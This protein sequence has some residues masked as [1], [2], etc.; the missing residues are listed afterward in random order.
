MSQ[1]AAK[2]AISVEEDAREVLED[3][4]A[5]RQIAAKLVNEIGAEFKSDE[6]REVLNDLAMTKLIEEFDRLV[7]SEDPSI[8]SL[9]ESYALEQ[10]YPNPFNPETEIRFQL[11]ATNHVVIK[12]FNALG[13][14]IRTLVNAQYEAGNHSARWDGKDKNGIPVASGV[15][16]YQLQAGAFSQVMKM[17]LVR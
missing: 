15:Y 8:A 4:N 12:I 1:V 10:N 2:A 13:Q 6:I 9:P 3:T 14:E 7:G 11:P 17:S 5:I 16:L